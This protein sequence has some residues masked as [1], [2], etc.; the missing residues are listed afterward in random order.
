MGAAIPLRGDFDAA[1]LRGLAQRSQDG[2]QNRRLLALA[3]IY[4]GHRRS[5]A[6]RFA[7]VGLQIVRDWVL[8]FNAEG[9]DGLL[10]RK[11]VGPP[12]K[13]SEEQR[14]ALAAIVESG[15]DPAVHGVGALAALR[16]GGMASGPVRRVVGG[17]DDRAEVA[18]DV[19]CSSS[20]SASRGSSRG[21]APV[22][23]CS[24]QAT[25]KCETGM[26]AASALSLIAAPLDRRAAQ[27]TANQPCHD[28]VRVAARGRP[29][30]R[31]RT[32][33]RQGT[34]RG[35]IR[36][37]LQPVFPGYDSSLL[38]HTPAR[39]PMRKLCR[40]PGSRR[41]IA[42]APTAAATPP[43]AAPALHELRHGDT[44]CVRPGGPQPGPVYPRDAVAARGPVRRTL[45]PVWLSMIEA[46]TGIHEHW[47]P[48]PRIRSRR[49]Q[50]QRTREPWRSRGRTARSVGRRRP[51]RETARAPPGHG[52][53]RRP[54]PPIR[55]IRGV[56]IRVR[57]RYPACALQPSLFS[58]L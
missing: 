34:E 29:P 1:K 11:A 39:N 15:P 25:R 31:R 10:D 13:L 58:G 16:P 47:A 46:D 55:T 52:K 36:S 21:G 30:G 44:G 4:D 40:P 12:R 3:A 2:A 41:A 5:G 17:D 26:P 9:P 28:P 20:V 35:E 37:S 14:A 48:A 38:S 54:G 6:A 45:L 18:P 49:S 57:R 7:G 24:A 8:R 23:S 27:G 51:M 33:C 53:A 32:A 19:R 50:R 22:S 56:R 43:A 42:A